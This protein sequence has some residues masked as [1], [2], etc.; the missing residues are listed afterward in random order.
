MRRGQACPGRCESVGTRRSRTRWFAPRFLGGGRRWR[1]RRVINARRKP[2]PGRRRPV[3]TPAAHIETVELAV[4]RRQPGAEAPPPLV[5][6]DHS[7]HEMACRV[8]E[9]RLRRD[10]ITR[11]LH[12]H[13]QLD[14]SRRQHRA[15]LPAQQ[16]FERG[17]APQLRGRR[18]LRP[19]RVGGYV[20]QRLGRG[21]VITRLAGRSQP[22]SRLELSLIH[23]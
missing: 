13:T 20:R 9:R 15:A 1:R 10:R 11:V 22:P 4:R 7:R 5:G 17:H 16:A 2:R 6:A 19:P 12:A 21:L 8:G 3:A 14:E 23:I 18:H